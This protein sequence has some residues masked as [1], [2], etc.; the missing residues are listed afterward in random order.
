MKK[1]WIWGIALFMLA[2]IYYLFNPSDIALFP[3]CP[4]LV[5]TGLKC[6]GCGS[7]RAI[8]SLLHFDL[9]AAFSYNMLLVL[10]LPIV[11]LLIYSEINRKRKPRFYMFVHN[12]KG[13]WIYLAMVIVWW[14][15][16]NVFEL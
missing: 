1:K 16:R 3:K 15:V 12:A 10:S 11:L 7:Q 8:H 2:G 13:I 14:V 5:L 9:A 4:F 6:P